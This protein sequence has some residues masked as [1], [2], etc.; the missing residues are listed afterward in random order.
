MAAPAPLS[1]SVGAA[2][3]AAAAADD[4]KENATAVAAH[5][6]EQV[7]R[8]VL[9]SNV[10]NS[11]KAHLRARL[12]AEFKGPSS[13]SGVC[14]SGGTPPWLAAPPRSPSLQ[15]HVLNCLVSEFLLAH[16]Y[17]YTLSVFLAE[18]GSGALPRLGRAD[19]LRLLGVLPESK[20]HALLTGASSTQLG[21]A[22]TAAAAPADG[23][24]GAAT[25]AAASL[26]ERM[27]AALGVLGGRVS[28]HV[29]ACQTGE[30][31]AGWSAHAAAGPTSSQQLAARLAA[32]E[33]E[34]RRKS[35]ALEAAA[36]AS[37]EERMAAY[38]RE[39]DARCAAQLEQRLAALRQSELAAVREEEAARHTAALAAEHA[40]LTAEHQQRL[41][42][43]H[44][45]EEELLEQGRRLHHEQDQL[46]E[47][48]LRRVRGDEE[49]LHAWR[50]AAESRLA[51]R[52]TA[53]R[54]QAEQAAAAAKA[55]AVEREEGERQLAAR[56]AELTAQ[57]A[58]AVRARAAAEADVARV[59]AL[60]RQLAA[61]LEEQG[62]LRQQ[63][64]STQ[65]AQQAEVA[66]LRQ[67]KERLAAAASAAA[68]AAASAAPV[69][70]AAEPSPQGLS[71]ADSARLQQAVRRLMQRVEQLQGEVEAGRVRERVWRGS[72]GEAEKLLGKSLKAHD[73]ALQHAEELRLA[74]ATAAREVADL[75]QQTVLAAA[76]AE[77][78]LAA[79]LQAACRDAERWCE[80]AE[81]RVGAA[82]QA[83]EGLRR[84]ASKLQQRAVASRAEAAARLQHVVG[85]LVAGR[86]QA[87]AVVA[88]A[89]GGDSS[90]AE[91]SPLVQAA[92]PASAP[93]QPAV[94]RTAGPL[95][96]AGLHAQQVQQVEQRVQ[97][98]QQQ[99]QEQPE[100]WDSSPPPL[101]RALPVQH[102][103]PVP[104]A[105]PAAP[106]G[107][108][109]GL[110]TSLFQQPAQALPQ[111][112]TAAAV[113][114]GE[115][116]K[117]PSRTASD[118]LAAYRSRQQ[119]R[120][121]SGSGAGALGLGGPSCGASLSRETSA[122]E[123]A[124]S[125]GQQPAAAAAAAA[126][127][128]VSPPPLA[129]GGGAGYSP[130]AAVAAAMA[131][132]AAGTAA[133]E[134]AGGDSFYVSDLT[135]SED[136]SRF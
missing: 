121:A 49:R 41:A 1:D 33:E 17:T 78:P 58:E 114:N 45:Q 112:T 31:S 39:C 134:A 116:S 119:Q 42:A 96:G 102:P 11:V 71:P 9:S 89:T 24:D 87:L 75:Q 67:E 38:Q 8:R 135:T 43:L 30:D 12:F 131:A 21:A 118:I 70:A 93:V 125:A 66:V 100:A 95:F 98:A 101:P 55:A 94:G 136:S 26:A 72:A 29:A 18:T 127:E 2:V 82:R 15:Q 37:L 20:V 48:H 65:A 91:E 69:T 110:L 108:S 56:L 64:S 122:S 115:A 124:G 88:G 10:I 97:L 120:S 47:E 105:Q 44:K 133:V 73:R 85:T 104:S 129:A 111:H 84:E 132:G 81:A 57:Q 4:S 109:F 106:A 5:L 130:A 14:G 46:R 79:A 32:I 50:A 92:A 86:R 123:E 60:Q 23:C 62:A 25:D 7:V 61:A 90:S 28:T 77:G 103:A 68:A 36:A 76:G 22:P 99:Q 63:L 51:V 126:G 34:Y 35:A 54:L 3:A 74:L 53:A 128:A 80:N 6:R 19:L 83:E 117:P 52:E 27:V 40:V 16:R 113:G 13:G 107:S 59:D